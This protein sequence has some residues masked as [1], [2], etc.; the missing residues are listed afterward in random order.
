MTTGMNRQKRRRH[1]QNIVDDRQEINALFREPRGGIDAQHFDEK[2]RAREDDLQDGFQFAGFLCRKDGAVFRY[3]HAQ[4]GNKKLAAND[5]QHAENAPCRNQ[6]LPRQQKKHADDK[7]FINQRIRQLSEIGNLMVFA[8]RPAVQPIGDARQNIQNKCQRFRARKRGVKEKT[9]CENQRDTRQRDRVRHI[10]VFI[11]YR[12]CLFGKPVLRQYRLR[13]DKNGEIMREKHSNAPLRHLAPRKCD[14]QNTMVK[15]ATAEVLK[16]VGPLVP[17]ALYQKNYR[18]KKHRNIFEYLSQSNVRC[19]F[20]GG[21]Y[22]AVV[23][24]WM[25]ESCAVISGLSAVRPSAVQESDRISDTERTIFG[26]SSMLI[27]ASL[28]IKKITEK[29]LTVRLNREIAVF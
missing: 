14:G 1:K 2:K 27:V 29:P 15:N 17:V 28:L 10:H 11:F 21:A 13:T 3:H 26:Y 22:R 24:I 16:I 5:K 7:N 9:D 12:Q 23:S 19:L 20:M 6:P 8:R 18:N 25:L 4:S